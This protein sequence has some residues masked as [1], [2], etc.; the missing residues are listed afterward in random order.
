[1]SREIKIPGME[2]QAETPENP[3]PHEIING[4]AIG[5]KT[6]LQSPQVEIRLAALCRL[7]ALE[8]PASAYLQKKSGD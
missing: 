8:T 7:A 4:G 6:Q 2:T 5:L 1:M 3:S